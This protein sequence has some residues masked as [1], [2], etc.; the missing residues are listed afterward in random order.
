MRIYVLQVATGREQG[1]IDALQ[2]IIDS[3]LRSE[4]MSPRYR[5]QKKVKGRWEM[6]EELLTP[7]YVFLKTSLS[8]IGDLAKKIKEAPGISRVLSRDGKFIPLSAEEVDWLW[9]LTGG[10]QVVEPS[11]GV[12]EGDRVVITRGPL[13]GFETQIRRIDRHKRLAYVDVRLMGRTKTIKV[14][15]EIVRKNTLCGGGDQGCRP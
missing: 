12:I 14:G 2:R 6:V 1:T 13:E 11:I 8:D 3:F 5:F 7:G 15:V 9:R 4:L 10:S